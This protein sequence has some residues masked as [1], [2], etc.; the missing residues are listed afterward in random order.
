MMRKKELY[1][2]ILI[3]IFAALTF[4]GCLIQI[5]LPSGGMIHL[6]NFVIIISALLCG[7]LIGGVSGAIGAGLYDLL[8]YS[9]VD[10]MIKYFILK[11]IMG[12]IVGSSFRLLLKKK[13]INSS[14][15]NISLGL[16]LILFTTLA[17]T[18]SLNGYISLSSKI[19]NV[20]LYLILVSIFGYIL[21][22]ILLVS[23][24]VSI[25]IKDIYKK[26][27]TAISLSIS[28]NV[29]LE[30]ILKILFS[31]LIDSLPF[32]AAFIKG[33]STM[34]ACI[35]TGTITLY[36]GVLIFPLLYKAT[37][38]VSLL[39]DDIQLYLD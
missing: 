8:I 15:I 2:L 26:S 30:F 3:S 33:V 35:L 18:L 1:K 32:E 25:R 6:G 17:L 12:Y 34:P 14:I 23:G 4:V 36:L 24:I 37:K 5:P 38:N 19:T 27:I 9:S 31:M 13:N 29:V 10:G 39:R 16:I 21:S 20:K 22:L 7:G 11:F 28:A